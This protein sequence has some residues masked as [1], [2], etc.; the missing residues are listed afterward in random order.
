[1]HFIQQEYHFLHVGVDLV[2]LRNVEETLSVAR[3]VY[4]VGLRPTDSRPVTAIV[5]REPDQDTP[6]A[7]VDRS[8]VLVIC[9]GPPALVLVRQI[10]I[11]I[12]KSGSRQGSNPSMY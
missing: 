1:M 3:P 12:A 6:V 5:L 11:G 9:P 4:P 7:V 8:H 2:K 10:G